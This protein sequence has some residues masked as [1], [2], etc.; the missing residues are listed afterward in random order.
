MAAASLAERYRRHRAEM[1]LALALGITPREAA[2]VLRRR[3]RA[4]ARAA[5]AARREATARCGT[6]APAE[7]EQLELGSATA[8][9]GDFRRWNASWM[10]RD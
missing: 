5:E 4:A 1:E 10:L 2:G 9:A 7:Q 6:A 3:E 8:V